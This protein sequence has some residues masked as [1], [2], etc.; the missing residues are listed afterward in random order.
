MIT[1]ENHIFR[2]MCRFKVILPGRCFRNL[3]SECLWISIGSFKLTRNFLTSFGS[4]SRF[5][6]C[7]TL[8]RVNPSNLAICA[9]ELTSPSSSISC[10]S[11]ALW[12]MCFPG[13]WLTNWEFLMDFLLSGKLY[14]IGIIIFVIRK[15]CTSR[16]HFDAKRVLSINR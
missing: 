3:L 12:I 7:V 8:A 13:E 6:I 15:S 5:M 1:Y 14:L 11:T 16:S 4:F 10:H 9:S 2:F